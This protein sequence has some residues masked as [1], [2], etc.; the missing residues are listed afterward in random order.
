MP[1]KGTITTGRYPKLGYDALDL[2]AHQQRLVGAVEVREQGIALLDLPSRRVGSRR[3]PL[4][5]GDRAGWLEALRSDRAAVYTPWLRSGGEDTA[6][7]LPP[8]AAAAGLMA[9]FEREQGVWRAPANRPARGILA[10]SERIDEE[11]AG[12]LHSERIN[13][14]RPTPAGWTLLGS[15]LTSSDPDWTHLSVRRLIDWLKLQIASELAWAPFE[16]NGPILWEAMAGIARRRLRQVFDAGG[17]AGATEEASFFARCD[18]AT[19]SVRERDAGRVVLLVG[20]APTQPAEFLVFELIRR[21]G[22]DPG[23]EVR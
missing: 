11:L 22:E 1:T 12:A 2:L 15:R 17:L 19:T 8:T 7:T 16:P 3:E 5:A 23:L 18:A 20:V 14:F 4:Q 10:A 21:G 9:S 6:F 13:A